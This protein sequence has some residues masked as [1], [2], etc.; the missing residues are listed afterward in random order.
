MQQITILYYI[1]KLMSK[2][3]GSKF[4]YYFDYKIVKEILNV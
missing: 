3:G 4:K 2:F 1:C